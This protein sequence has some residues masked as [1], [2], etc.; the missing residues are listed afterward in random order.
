MDILETINQLWALEHSQYSEDQRMYPWHISPLKDALNGNL[1][2]C[3][4]NNRG[5]NKWQIVFIG[6]S[7]EA[8]NDAI[9]RLKTWKFMA[10]KVTFE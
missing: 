4:Y 1:R 7:P 2:D 10:V 8:C 6:P 9:T 3:Q 5:S